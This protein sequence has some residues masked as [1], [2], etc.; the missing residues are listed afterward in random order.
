VGDPGAHQGGGGHLALDGRARRRTV[1]ELTARHPMSPLNRYWTLL[2]G[3]DRPDGPTAD[4]A[5]AVLREAGLDPGVV[6]WS[7]PR[8]PEGDRDEFVEATRRALCLP[9]G[10]RAELEAV[11]RDHPVPPTRELVTLWWDRR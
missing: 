9:A 3:L 1:V 5:V 10:R 8:T 4:D 11:L 6:R 7:R 2:H